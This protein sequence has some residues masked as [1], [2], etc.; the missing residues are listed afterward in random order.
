M[1]KGWEFI[2]SY[3]SLSYSFG[4]EVGGLDLVWKTANWWTSLALVLDFERGDFS[5]NKSPNSK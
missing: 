3:D 5:P 1:N 2:A 4:E